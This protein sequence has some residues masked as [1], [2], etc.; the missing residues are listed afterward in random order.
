MCGHSIA[1][2]KKIEFLSLLAG[3]TNESIRTSTDVRSPPQFLYVF[4]FAVSPAAVD[5]TSLRLLLASCLFLA[6]LKSALH[7]VYNHGGRLVQALV[8]RLLLEEMKGQSCV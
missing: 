8:T 2:A 4:I 5:S 6:G 3:V 7:S 1:V